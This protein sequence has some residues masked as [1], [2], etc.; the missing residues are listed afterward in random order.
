MAAPPWSGRP[1]TWRPDATTGWCSARPTPSTALLAQL[2]D[3]RSFGPAR[4]AAVG[5][6]TAET[7]ARWRMVPDLVPERAVAE[8][9]LEA[10]PDPPGPGPASCCREPP[11]VGTSCP[12]PGGGG[13]GV[14]AVEA[15]RTVP[16]SADRRRPGGRGRRRRRVLRLGIGG[17][18]ASRRRGRPGRSCPPVVVCIGPSTAAAAAAAGLAVTCRRRA[19]HHPRPGRGPAAVLKR[20]VS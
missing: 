10:F 11:R 6:G 12:R 15:Y 18:A 5:P 16:V 4:I 3:A 14:D 19:P 9:L 2:A 8:G 7:L 20:P 13:L 17:Q 1:R